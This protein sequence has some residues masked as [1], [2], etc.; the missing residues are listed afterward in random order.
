MMNDELEV[1]GADVL[2]GEKLVCLFKPNKEN[3]AAA[4]ERICEKISG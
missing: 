4:V 2:E 1:S 3:M